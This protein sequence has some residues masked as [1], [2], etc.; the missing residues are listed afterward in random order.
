MDLFIETPDARSTTFLCSMGNAQLWQ[1]DRIT[2]P[3]SVVEQ[4]TALLTDSTYD[5]LTISDR[6][7]GG[8][9]Y[10]D[11]LENGSRRSLVYSYF[12][13]LIHCDSIPTI[14]NRYITGALLF[15][16]TR[17]GNTERW[18]ILMED[19]KKVGMLYDTLGSLFQDGLSF[20]FDHVSDASGPLLALFDSISVRPEQRRVLE[21]AAEKGYYETPRQ[22]TLD[23]L[24]AEL[25]W[26]RST[27]SY[28]LRQ[29]EAALVEE[30]MS[31]N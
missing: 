8:R 24:A 15:E 10:S 4:A 19:E 26:P 9:R 12:E 6:A 20:H 3:S 25:D 30:Y 11:V 2:G 23:E 18:R 27:V 16:V 5:Q 1:L 21:L 28:R 14:T 22:T 17:N 31:V 29:A 7:C 13:Q